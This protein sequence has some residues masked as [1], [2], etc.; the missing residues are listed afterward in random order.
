MSVA[1]SKGVS[2]SVV[3]K[4]VVGFSVAALAIVGTLAPF[5]GINI[6]PTGESAAALIG[7]I[8]GAVIALR[9]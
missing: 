6:T 2:F 8:L 3:F 4:A 5:A 1:I 7:A 9:G